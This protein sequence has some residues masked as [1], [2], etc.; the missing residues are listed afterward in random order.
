[1]VIVLSGDFFCS[2]WWV[3]LVVVGVVGLRAAALGLEGGVSQC[4]W[5]V[6]SRYLIRL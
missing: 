2:G 6:K 3:L 1:M 5:T 4:G